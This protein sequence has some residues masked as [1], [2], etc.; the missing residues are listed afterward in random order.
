MTGLIGAAFFCLKR[1][2]Q[3]QKLEADKPL[4]FFFVRLWVAIFDNN[5]M[6]CGNANSN[7]LGKNSNRYLCK[8]MLC[9]FEAVDNFSCLNTVGL[10]M[11]NC[12]AWLNL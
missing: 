1:R 2:N 6:F 10:K 3:T 12:L 5:V 4:P 9:V 11:H 7:F 8:L